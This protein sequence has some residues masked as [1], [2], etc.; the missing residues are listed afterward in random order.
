MIIHF[1]RNKLSRIFILS[2]IISLLL[3]GCTSVGTRTLPKNQS[4][5]NYAMIHSTEQQLLLNL[6]RIQFEDRPFFLSV[7]SITTSNSLSVSGGPSLNYSPSNSGSYS[8]SQ[9]GKGTVL[10]QSISKSFSLSRSFGFSPNA[11]YSDSPTISYSPL[12]GEKFTRQMLTSVNT[13]TIYLLLNSG[14]NPVRVMRTMVERLD[15]YDNTAVLSSKYIP[16]SNQFNEIV[17]LIESLVKEKAIY[18]STGAITSISATRDEERPYHR[19][20]VAKAQPQFKKTTRSHKKYSSAKNMG[21]PKKDN[22][23]SMQHNNKAGSK[24]S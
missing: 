6:I 9:D 23:L 20:H 15:D 2:I 24:N 8:A 16:Q 22:H 11:S 1:G 17:D 3:G 7:E 19:K 4:G 12:Q 13:N 14:W 21:L 18:F 10:S 5:F